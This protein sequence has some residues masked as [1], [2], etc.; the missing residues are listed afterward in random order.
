MRVY[1]L[2]TGSFSVCVC[3]VFDLYLYYTYP[4]LFV[5]GGKLVPE[6]FNQRLC[7]HRWTLSRCLL[8]CRQIT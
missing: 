7:G 5:L 8:S 2:Q 6:L 3:V 4:L 1:N